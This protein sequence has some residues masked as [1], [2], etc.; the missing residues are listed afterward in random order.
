[1]NPIL[2]FSGK[3]FKSKNQEQAI[4]ITTT[5]KGDCLANFTV[6]V[7]DTYRKDAG[8]KYKITY[9]KAVEVWGK[10]AEFCKELKEGDRVVIAAEEF[11]SV[12]QKQSG[13]FD[14]RTKYRVINIEFI[15]RHYEE[16]QT[17]NSQ[18]VPE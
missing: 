3:V 1:M 17:Y 16:N 9:F 7:K 14:K 2:F 6:I 13:E 18:E 11:D 15:D 8:D 4:K 12:F 10:Q 5:T